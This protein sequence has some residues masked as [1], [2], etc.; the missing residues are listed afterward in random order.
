MRFDIGTYS[1]TVNIPTRD[2]LLQEV[3]R[4]FSAGEG[5]ALATLNLDHL[6]KLK[7][8]DD[9]RQAY[10]AQDFVVADGNPIV[11]MSKLAGRPVGLAPGSELIEPIAKRAAA[12]GVS[13]GLVGSTDDVL[14]AA[15]DGLLKCV[16]GLNISARIAPPMG[17]DPD[18]PDADAIFEELEISGTRMVFLA[19]GAP[20]QERM[21]ARG[22][23]IVPQI[24][25]ASIGA[26]L[27]F[28]SGH[29][30]RAPVI[31]RKLALE[32]LWRMLSNPRRL[33]ARYM[34]CIA[35]LPRHLFNALRL[36]LTSE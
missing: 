26:G 31:V 18:G 10:A 32:W 33:F 20:K 17:F 27:D 15:E 13:V 22:R 5:F 8:D 12:A 30:V 19:L 23:H 35:I 11:W 14:A 6:V 24:G 3:T 28:I 16:P 21:A 25:F 34:M 9:F 29:Q 36:R 2:K 1:L 7:S 4:R